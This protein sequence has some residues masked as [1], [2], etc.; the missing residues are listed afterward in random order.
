VRLSYGVPLISTHARA[1][2]PSTQRALKYLKPPL[3]ALELL[4]NG[5]PRD[6]GHDG[7]LL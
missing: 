4:C 6:H 1:V 2:N 7:G 5:N 3:G